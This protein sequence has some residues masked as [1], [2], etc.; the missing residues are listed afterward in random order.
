MFQIDHTGS[1]VQARPRADQDDYSVPEPHGNHGVEEGDI[2]EIGTADGGVLD[3]LVW[4][5]ADERI[6]LDFGYAAA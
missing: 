5:V 3:A 1:Q 4:A 6:Y 2:L